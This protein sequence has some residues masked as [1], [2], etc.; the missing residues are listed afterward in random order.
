[1]AD[2]VGAGERRAP[3]EDRTDGEAGA[4]GRL[5]FLACIGVLSLATM[6]ADLS[7]AAGV[8]GGVVY[9]AVVLLG[10]WA[11]KPAQVVALAAFASLL[12][13]AGFALRFEEAVVQ[14][15]AVDRVIA[16]LAIWGTAALLVAVKRREIAQD[17]GRRALAARGDRESGS[18]GKPGPISYAV[19]CF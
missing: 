2:A 17:R 13:L 10:W 6:T 3:P 4:L 16:L 7:V 11:R 15:A 5:R 8:A 19:F 12:V 9:L 14:V 1:M 18:A